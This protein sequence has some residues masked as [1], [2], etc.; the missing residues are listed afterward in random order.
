VWIAR[1]KLNKPLWITEGAKKVLKLVQHERATIGLQGVWNFR[2]G[3]K[4]AGLEKLD[5]GISGEAA[6][7]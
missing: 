7:Q 4:R 3:D 6:L 2:S 5:S 1:E